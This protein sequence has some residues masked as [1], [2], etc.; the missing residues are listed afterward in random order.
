MLSPATDPAITSWSRSPKRLHQIDPGLALADMFDLTIARRLWDSLP[1]ECRSDHFDKKTMPAHYRPAIR[2]VNVGGGW[3]SCYLNFRGLPEPMTWEIAWIIHRRIELGHFV[4]VIETNAVFTLLRAAM[5]HDDECRSAQSLLHRSPDEWVRSA[6]KAQMRGEKIG[7]SAFKGGTY[8]LGHMAAVLGYA[9][10]RGP[11]WELNVWNPS[12]DPRVPQRDHEPQ[13]RTTMHFTNLTSMWLREGAKYWL[14]AGLTTERYS[15][16]TIKSRLDALKWLQRYIDTTADQGPCLTTDPHRLRGFIRGFCDML[17]AH[18]IESGP[19]AGR[20]LA[21][22]PRRQIMTAIEQFYQFMY[23]HRD[24]AATELGISA[25]ATL[26]PE[27]C[28]LFRPED[29]PRLTNVKAHDMVLEDGVMQQIA[30]GSGLLA[31][32]VQEGGL[33]DLQAFHIMMLLLRTGRRANEVLMMDFD[34]LEPMLR[35]SA[36]GD[37]DGAGFVAR[38]RYQQT[39][40]ESN[41]A[42]TIPVDEEIVTIIRAQQKHAREMMAHFGNPDVTPKYLFLRTTRNRLGDKP[43]PL[44]TMHLRFSRLTSLLNIRDSVGRQV[45]VSKTHRF[46]HTAATNLINAGVPLHVVMRYFGHISPDMTLHYAVTSAQTMEE[47][48][49]RYKKVTRDGR[50]ASIDSSDLYDL[51]QLDKRA[52][53]ILPNGWCTLPPKQLCDKGNAC[54]SCSKFVTDS[55]HAPQLR[56]QLTDTET[57]IEH[58]QAVFT[59]KYG[60]PMDETN[61]WLHGRQIEVD[62]LNRILLSI[63]DVSATDKAVR[64]PGTTI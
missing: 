29:K 50:T 43:Y 53:R 52:D 62:S 3:T 4:R 6:R 61:I 28:V 35:N 51:I 42:P 31:Q 11:W 30:E 32:P 41:L 58:R 27:H 23:D 59:A 7:E 20:P 47:E 63:N 54:L 2:E 26:R 16:S 15:W 39:K 55:T 10:H 25:W 22:N 12:L 13:G 17:L 49:L 21:K 56:T 8:R 40:I 60:A 46:R 37:P 33:G 5:H 9:Y 44:P 19:R 38:M 14:S 57:L 64:G 36:A 45:A 24:E 18:R 34:P 48:F 1:E